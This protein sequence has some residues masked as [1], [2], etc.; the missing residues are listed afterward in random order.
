MFTSV[1]LQVGIYILVYSIFELKLYKT[2]NELLSWL[3]FVYAPLLNSAD[4]TYLQD[5]VVKSA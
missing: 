2:Q 1:C 3:P 4:F 5:K